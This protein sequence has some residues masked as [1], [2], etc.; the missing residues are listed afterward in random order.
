MLFCEVARV[1]VAVMSVWNHAVG[2]GRV[3]ACCFV[4]HR[5]GI[6]FFPRG[7]LGFVFFIVFIVLYCIGVLPLLVLCLLPAGV[8]VRFVLTNVYLRYHF[9]E[10]ICMEFYYEG[11]DEASVQAV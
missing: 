4:L 10:P 7:E 5:G 6:S 3:S 9:S 1:C 8:I 2:E 11:I